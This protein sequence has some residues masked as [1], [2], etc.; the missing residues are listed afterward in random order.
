VRGLG[1][2]TRVIARLPA[3]VTTRVETGK[4]HEFAVHADRL[5]YFDAGTGQQR[6][7]P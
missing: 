6:P 7:A 5:R 1:E 2:E 3:T 4:E